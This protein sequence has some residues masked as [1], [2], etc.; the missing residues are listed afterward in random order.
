[1]WFGMGMGCF[2]ITPDDAD[3]FGR[4]IHVVPGAVGVGAAGVW[5]TWGYRHVLMI[6]E[7]RGYAKNFFLQ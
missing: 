5:V 7:C 6:L 4:A 1:M 3:C 2:A